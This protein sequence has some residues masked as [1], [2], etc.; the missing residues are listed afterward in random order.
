MA[1][2]SYFDLDRL[3]AYSTVRRIKLVVAQYKQSTAD[4]P[5]ALV[6]ALVANEF[7]DVTRK[8]VSICGDSDTIAAIAGSA[9]EARFGIPE[10]IA[11]KTWSYLPRDMREVLTRLYGKAKNL[12][13]KK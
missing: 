10:E 4:K 9:V 6:G 13:S 3:Q 8:A 11:A 7:E 12:D 5:Q 1:P 2:S